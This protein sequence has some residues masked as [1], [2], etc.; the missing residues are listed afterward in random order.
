MIDDEGVE[1]TEDTEESIINADLDEDDANL[2]LGEE[3]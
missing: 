2:D 3:L 1:I